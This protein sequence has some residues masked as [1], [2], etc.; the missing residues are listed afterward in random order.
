M[1]TRLFAIFRSIFFASLFI[2]LWTWLIPRWIAAGVPLVP[3]WSAAAVA[4]MLPGAA[5]M[6]Q[7]IFDFAWTGRGTPAPW[8]PPRRL[9]VRGLY[10]WVRNPMYVGMGL[11]LIG[12]ALLLPAVTRGMLSMVAIFWG[13]AT[14]FIVVYEEPVLRAKFDGDY[15]K[16]CRNVRRWLPRLTPFDMNATRAVP[17]P[18]LE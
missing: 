18:D 14:I 1:A 5:I 6:L 11:F 12:E 10:R 2:W 9:V 16:Y 13:L 4:L 8:D 7:C 3:R 15:R 17:S